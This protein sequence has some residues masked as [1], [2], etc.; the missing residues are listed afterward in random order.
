MTDVIKPCLMMYKHYYRNRIHR[1]LHCSNGHLVPVFEVNFF[2]VIILFKVPAV[3]PTDWVL[4]L[5]V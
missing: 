4:Y 1:L 5:S 3:W 2:K